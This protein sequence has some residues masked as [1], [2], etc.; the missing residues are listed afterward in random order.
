LRAARAI[1]RA[2]EPFYRLGVA[3][4][5]RLYASGLLRLRRLPVPVISVGNLTAG[6]SGKTPMVEW[7]VSH[8]RR[9]GRRPAVVSRGYGALAKGLAN[10]EARVLE[11]NLPGVVLLADPDRAE[12]GWR[13]VE[14]H[15]ADCIVLDDG[16]Q[17]IRL[18]RDLD[19]VL[20]DALDPFGG[21]RLLPAGALREPAT[22]LR[23][24][25]VVVLTRADLVPDQDREALAARVAGLAPDALRV[26]AGSRLLSLDPV[27][28]GAPQAPEWL[29][30][31]RVFAF[32]GLGNPW[33]F[34]RQLERLYPESLDAALLDDHCAYP[35]PLIESLAR[36]AE[37][38]GAE[39]VVMTQKDAVKIGD[40]WPGPATAFALNARIRI[41]SG[42]E[43]FHAR[44][45]DVS[46]AG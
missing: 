13:A 37:T 11:A 5:R 34:V 18:R 10:D 25:H 4:R 29:G 39:A 8:L 16:F 43:A 32:C 12:A 40:A 23:R 3:A 45:R 44:L 41:M 31:K 28:R 26:E 22:A 33:G 9:W 35:L 15:D 17:H 30:H 27:G 1:L 14:E 36:E 42:S 46:V 20:I 7:I 38:A 19:I 24:A 2:L 21:D 6:G